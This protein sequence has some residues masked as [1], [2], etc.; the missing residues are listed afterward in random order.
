MPTDVIETLNNH[1]SVRDFTDAPLDDETLFKILRA[2]RRSPTSSNLQT[3]SLVV[4]CDQDTKKKLAAIAGNQRHIETCP[5]FIALCADVSRLKLA[6]NLHGK[7]YVGN[8]ERSLVATVDAALVGMSL[9]LAAESLGLGTVM[10]GA[11]RND[12]L[13]A[14]R[15]LGLPDGAF[16]VF[17]LCIGWPEERPPQKPRLPEELVIHFERY[18]TDRESTVERLQAHD[19]DLAEHYRS[20]GRETPDAAWTGTSARIASTVRRPFL[21]QVLTDLG[22]SLD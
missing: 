15:L 1:V 4:V 12:P 19:R 2:A 6:C 14:A 22:L 7:T 16:V 5:V 3:Y 20:L 17:G 9:S 13:A 8:L 11:I 21:R 18:D 10:I